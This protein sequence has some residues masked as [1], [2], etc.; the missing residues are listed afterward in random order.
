MKI[1]VTVEIDSMTITKSIEMNRGNPVFHA[2][3]VAEHGS[4]LARKLGALF[5]DVHTRPMNEPVSQ[6]GL[7]PVQEH[8]RWA[9][10]EAR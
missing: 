1:T 5:G 3:M 4:L 9:Q 7:D 6:T 8:R 2:Y 10:G